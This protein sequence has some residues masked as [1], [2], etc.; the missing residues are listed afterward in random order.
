MAAFTFFPT[1]RRRRSCFHAKKK[2]DRTSVSEFVAK[3]E[4]TEVHPK[5][6]FLSMLSFSWVGIFPP[7]LPFPGCGYDVVPCAHCTAMRTK[8]NPDGD[9]IDR[10]LGVVQMV[11]VAHILHG[12]LN[13]SFP[14]RGRGNVVSEPSL[15]EPILWALDA[16][17]R[18]DLP[19]AHYWILS[20]IGHWT[21]IDRLIDS[22]Y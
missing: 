21:L 2:L 19:M 5:Y 3:K 6:S 14:G 1:H 15:G 9:C 20:I 18:D 7:S 13:C 16:E 17:M 12:G 8:S 22:V 10:V 11:R 4:P